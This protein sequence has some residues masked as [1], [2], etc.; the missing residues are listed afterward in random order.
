MLFWASFYQKQYLTDR[1]I[2]SIIRK[3]GRD[4]RQH[5]FVISDFR[6]NSGM[7]LYEFFTLVSEISNLES[8]VNPVSL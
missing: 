2:I 4:F 3:P 7:L 8:E 1:K 6:R 5:T